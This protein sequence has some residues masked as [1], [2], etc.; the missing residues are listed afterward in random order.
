[1]IGRKE[2][3]YPAP[4]PQS[5]NLSRRL[6]IVMMACLVFC[7]ILALDVLPS[8]RGDFGWRWP[9]AVPDWSR[10][11]PAAVT[12]AIYILGAVRIRSLRGLLLWCFAGAIAISIACLYVLGDPLYLLATR[13]LS[14]LATGAHLAG[15]E[16]S[17]ALVT[18]RN[19]SEIMPTYLQPGQHTMLSVHIALSPP[20]LPLFYYALDRVLAGVPALADPL[21]MALRPL[22]CQ[23]YAIMAYSNAQLASAWVGILMPV[24]AGLTVFP[25]YRAGGRLAAIWWPL[26]PSLALFAPTWNTVYP[27]LGLV[28]YLLLNAGLQGSLT[29]HVRLREVLSV[30]AAGIVVSAATFANISLV[31]L[32][33]FFGLY[34]G[35]VYVRAV[36]Q[37]TLQA[38][39]AL[40]L[41]GMIGVLFVAG[42]SSIWILYYAVSGVTPLAILAQALGQHLD[43]NRPYLPWVFLHL[44]DLALF[45]GLPVV[46]LALVTIARGVLIR[47]PINPD[48]LDPLALALALTLILLAISGTARGETGRVWL[49]FVPFMLILAARHFGNSE[50]SS[51]ALVTVTQ[52]ITLITLAAFLRVMGTELNPPPAG[53]PSEQVAVDPLPSPATFAGSFT[54]IGSR[55]TPNGDGIDL[56]LSW[57]SDRQVATPYYLSALVVRP[58]GQPLP[59]AVNWQPFDTR[60]PTTCWQPGQIITETRRLPLGERPAP[61]SYWVS[62][63][64]FDRR[65]GQGIPVTQP[66]ADPATQIGLGPIP[67]R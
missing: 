4:E 10:L 6:V 45:T 66:G 31:P 38:R 22:Q 33:A 63:S 19:W 8:L 57:R 52:A 1:M 47:R 39:H 67:V 7:V 12:V 15:T 2:N 23:N 61:G 62:L 9:Y 29:H 60:Y 56:T 64:A 30:L 20:G 27:L 17:D 3:W 16:I 37:H 21:G 14:G 44:Y 35:L 54:L 5:L 50:R 26:V 65:D 51:A 28:A 40:S 55:A 32:I 42:T 41:A 13:T 25:L 49:F 34:C 36:R 43:L 53:P 59:P 24:W 58:D 11:W 48:K 46:C 18:A